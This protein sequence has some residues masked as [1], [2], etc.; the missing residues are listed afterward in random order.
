MLRDLHIAC[1][2]STFGY[3]YPNLCVRIAWM[4]ADARAAKRFCTGRSP[5]ISTQIRARRINKVKFR[6]LKFSTSHNHHDI[7]HPSNPQK[8]HADP[9]LTQSLLCTQRRDATPLGHLH[10]PV[11]LATNFDFSSVAATTDLAAADDHKSG[12]DEWLHQPPFSNHHWFTLLASLSTCHLS[13]S[14]ACFLT[15]LPLINFFGLSLHYH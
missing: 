11:A 12:S 10:P 8:A 9:A 5:G 1:S 7:L 13:I 6:H 14:L 4:A 15:T 2:T 3:L